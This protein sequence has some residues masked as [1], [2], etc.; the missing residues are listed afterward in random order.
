MNATMND[1]AVLIK[2]KS[3]SR[4]FIL[5]NKER[6]VMFNI[7]ILLYTILYNILLVQL[8]KT[9]SIRKNEVSL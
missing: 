9:N 8:L 2:K 3:L 5:N 4:I 6:D 1:I 7:V